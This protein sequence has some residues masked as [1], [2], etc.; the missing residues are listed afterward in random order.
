MVKLVQLNV[1]LVDDCIIQRVV[2][3]V[4]EYKSLNLLSG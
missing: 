1:E 4:R 3:S 2:I